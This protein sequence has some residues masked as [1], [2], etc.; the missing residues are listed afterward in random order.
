LVWTLDWGTLTNLDD[1][2]ERN[3]VGLR[4][5]MVEFYVLPDDAR[6]ALQG[7]CREELE[8]VPA[9]DR[10]L[11]TVQRRR[12]LEQHGELAVEHL[13]RQLR[14]DVTFQN[15]N[16]V[17]RNQPGYDYVMDNRVR[18]QVKG[19]CWVQMVDFQAKPLSALR[20]WESDLFILANFAPLIDGRWGKHRRE[21]ELAP[22]A[23]MDFYIA[24]TNEIMDLVQRR[25]GSD[26]DTRIRLF[27][28]TC[29]E[30]RR[31]RHH[32]PELA[33]YRNAWHHLIEA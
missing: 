23:N 4:I 19:R 32:C 33:V 30:K 18:V 20:Y 5:F 2:A 3:H 29:S 10:S 28:G 26:S 14:P 21:D 8:G 1:G 12:L 6:L 22:K 15:A 11:P 24:P 17:R 7:Y 25:Y 27:L 9:S 31:S 13:V 16:E